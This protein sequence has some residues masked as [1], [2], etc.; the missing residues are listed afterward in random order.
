MCGAPVTS[1]LFA[2]RASLEVLGPRHVV[3]KDGVGAERNVA[4]SFIGRNAMGRL[5]PL[6]PFVDERKSRGR[7]G[8]AARRV[9]RSNRSSSGVSSNLS[10]R[11]ASSLR[12]VTR[13]WSPLS[14][15]LHRLLCL[16]V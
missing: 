14:G 1:G 7:H 15:R 13:Y 2:K 5:E 4:R 9:M 8:L 3:V 10:L 12:F 16:F 6:P 11:T